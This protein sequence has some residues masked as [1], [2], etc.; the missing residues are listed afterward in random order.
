MTW[1]CQACATINAAPWGDGA[2]FAQQGFCMAG[3][4]MVTE[5]LEW[6]EVESSGVY[7]EAPAAVPAGPD[8]RDLFA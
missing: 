8:Q 5:R 1:H 3:D 7:V 2:A 6:H 4:H